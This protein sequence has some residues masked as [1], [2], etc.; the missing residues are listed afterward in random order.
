M[1]QRNYLQHGSR[2][3]PEGTDPIPGVGGGAWA[4]LTG[5][6]FYFLAGNSST[7]PATTSAPLSFQ[8]LTVGGDMNVFATHNTVDY[9][10]YSGV[11]PPVGDFN[12]S[13]GDTWVFAVKSGFL[14]FNLDLIWTHPTA[15]F[16]LN[17]AWNPGDA[18]TNALPFGPQAWEGS[19][20]VFSAMSMQLLDNYIGDLPSSQYY[21]MLVSVINDDSSSHVL[22]SWVLTISWTSTA[23]SQQNNVY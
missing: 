19:G 3:R 1:T 5:H 8:H 18:P 9:P 21:S 10:G 7:L 22:D 6:Q 12:N 23:P 4:I 13:A 2:H 15:A 11:V 16:P 14:T 20:D 17:V